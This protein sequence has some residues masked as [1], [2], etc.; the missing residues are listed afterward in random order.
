MSIWN[1]TRC[2]KRCTSLR[3]AHRDRDPAWPSAGLGMIAHFDDREAAEVLLGLDERT[4]RC[5]G[6]RVMGEHD[7]DR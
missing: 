7:D 2:G 5:H 3:P 1:Y 4:R 6:Q